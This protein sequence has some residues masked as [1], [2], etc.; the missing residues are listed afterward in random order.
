M[1]ISFRKVLS[2]STLIW[3]GTQHAMA[4]EQK[5]IAVWSESMNKE[6]KTTVITPDDYNKVN[7]FPVIYLLHGHGGNHTVW[8]KDGVVGKLADEYNVI[9]VMPDG[10]RD[11]WYFDSPVAAEYRYETFVGKELVAHIDSCYST[12]QDRKYR[13][14][15]GL[16]MGG[17]GAFYLAMKHQDIFGNMGSMS[18]GLDIRPFP[19]NWNIASRLGTYEEYEDRWNENTVINMTHLLKPD[20]MNII[21]DCGM[22][23]FFYKVNCDMHEKLKKEGIPHE[24]YVRPGAHNW[25][26]WMNAV[27]YQFLYFCNNFTSA[28]KQGTK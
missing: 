7:S 13:A 2:L 6:V 24:F 23:D 4:Y 26:Y 27:K 11:S 3:M 12:L 22:E 28:M 1:R 10:A 19:K 21:F 25:P 20:S 9:V 5:E 17:H 14:I 16:S 8:T 15:T 18:G